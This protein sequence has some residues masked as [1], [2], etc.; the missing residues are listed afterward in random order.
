[1]LTTK[2]A[3]KHIDA[4]YQ[5]ATQAQNDE[6]KQWYFDAN[7]FC[8]SLS[9]EYQV[10]L[11]TV[12]GILAVLSPQCAWLT[13]KEATR[14]ILHTGT[15]TRQCYP[16]NIKKAQRILHGE[17]FQD[18]MNHKRYGRKVRAFYDN[19]L[20]PSESTLV[21]VDTHAARAAFN[22]FDLTQSEIRWVF[23]C[24]GN[25]IIQDAY[26]QVAKVYGV[27]PLHLQATVWLYVKHKM[28]V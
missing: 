23:E 9:L 3:A 4:H 11:A 20:Q 15:T 28:E 6:G 14:D 2:Q 10:P 1:M 26:R 21:T 25:P 7:T 18:V 16:D 13:N 17:T 5:N 22:R 19:I 24:G 8:Y 12:V 27:S